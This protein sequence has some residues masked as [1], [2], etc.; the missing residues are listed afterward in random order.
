MKRTKDTADHIRLRERS[1]WLSGRNAPGLMWQF[2]DKQNIQTELLSITGNSKGQYYRAGDW[3]TASLPFVRLKLSILESDFAKMQAAAKGMGKDPLTV[4]PH[5]MQS[6][7]DALS[8]QLD[9][10]MEEQEA[11]EKILKEFADKQ[12]KEDESHLLEYG[13]KLSGHFWGSR[14]TSPDLINVLSDL[15][16]QKI[17][18]DEDGLLIIDSGPYRGMSVPDYR[19][20]ALKWQAD[21]RAAD[22]EKLLRMQEEA[23]L[24]G[25]P[26]PIILP[27][28]S[29]KIAPA[30]L[31][32][33]P[34]YAINHYEKSKK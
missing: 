7:H 21:R 31:P 29:R 32:P 12:E 9:I 3:H 34:S 30:N 2:R 1:P 10:L 25:K 6:K 22:K 26:Q 4:M 24:L 15:D 28:S 13:L 23:R 33:W 5:E 20:L 8:V 18:Q 16:G 19:K 17:V 14:A 27:S 11:L